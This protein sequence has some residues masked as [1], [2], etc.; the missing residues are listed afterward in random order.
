MAK[1]QGLGYIS[2]HSKA[3]ILILKK[4]IN[5][6]ARH[7]PRS[8]GE[9]AELVLLK[10]TTLFLLVQKKR[11]RKLHG[12]GSETRE[13]TPQSGATFKVLLPFPKAN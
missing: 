3:N 6:G 4:A 11:A 10:S 1:A 5:K 9:V 2:T 12:F 7:L 13:L 8:L